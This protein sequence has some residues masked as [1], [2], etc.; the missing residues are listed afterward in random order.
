MNSLKFWKPNGFDIATYK[1]RLHERRNKEFIGNG[2]DKG[3]ATYNFNELGFRGDSP[4]R[5]GFKIMSVGC[6]HTEGID[7]YDH[8]TWSHYFSQLIPK[9]IDINLGMSGRSNDYIARS[10][11]TYVD[12]F[13]PDLILIMYTYPDRCEYYTEDG[14]VEPYHKK[15]W[16]YLDEDMTGRIQW[17]GMVNASNS[18]NDLM[19]WYKNH[20]LITYYLKSKNIPFVWN[21]TFVGTDYTDENR[22]DG[23]YP[24]LPDNDKHATYLENKE[25]AE[26]LYNHIEKVGIIK[27]L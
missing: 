14:G 2:S 20:Q 1:W 13:K 16:G 11:M 18:S 3:K 19:N 6:S 5:T 12:E 15:P 26:K 24:N 21:G 23:D 9:G 22:F 17:A 8:Q 27:N 10:I 4:K 7:V 25:Y